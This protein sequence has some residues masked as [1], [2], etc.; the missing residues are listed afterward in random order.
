MEFYAKYHKL[1]AYEV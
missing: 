1:E